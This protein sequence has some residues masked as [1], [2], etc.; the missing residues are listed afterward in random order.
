MECSRC[1]LLNEPSAAVCGACGTGL[2]GWLCPNAAC[3]RPRNADAAALACA[4]C[5]AHRKVP[6]LLASPNVF[7]A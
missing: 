6:C 5:G 2:G 7:R 4:A 1:T 3:A